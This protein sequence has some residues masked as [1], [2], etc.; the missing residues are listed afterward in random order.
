MPRSHTALINQYPD[1]ER[2]SGDDHVQPEKTAD[3]VGEE[4][5]NKERQI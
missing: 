2:D 5:L 1:P 3:P 4:L